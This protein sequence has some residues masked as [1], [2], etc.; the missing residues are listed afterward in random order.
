M[1]DSIRMSVLLTVTMLVLAV[2]VLLCSCDSAQSQLPEEPPQPVVVYSDDV[3][4]VEAGVSTVTQEGDKIRVDI[5][6]RITNN[7]LE[8]LAISSVLGVRAEGAE[9]AAIPE[10][11]TP[12]D[13]LIK[14]GMSSEGYL[15]LLTSGEQKILKIEM[16]VDFLDDQWISFEI[17]L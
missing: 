11:L 5:P 2:T 10:E 15:T 6:L 13:G 3:Y 17:S 1:N 12:I 14:P 7:S 9:L 4:L 16:A 8:S